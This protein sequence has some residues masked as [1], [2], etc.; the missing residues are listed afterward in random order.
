MKKGW[1]PGFGN[2]NKFLVANLAVEVGNPVVTQPDPKGASNFYSVSKWCLPAILALQRNHG[3][4][5]SLKKLDEH[6]QICDL[7]LKLIHLKDIHIYEVIIFNF[8]YFNNFKYMFN[9]IC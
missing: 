2:P 3:W 7:G 8:I 5:F 1:Q 4:R 6:F 9:S